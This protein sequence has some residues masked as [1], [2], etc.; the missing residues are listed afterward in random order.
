MVRNI[1][2]LVSLMIASKCYA[3]DTGNTVDAKAIYNAIKQSPTEIKQ[4]GTGYRQLSKLIPGVVNCRLTLLGWDV[5]DCSFG[6]TH[7]GFSLIDQAYDMLDVE[8]ILIK[9]DQEGKWYKK[10]VG[11]LTCVK[12]IFEKPIFA[13]DVFYYSKSGCQIKLHMGNIDFEHLPL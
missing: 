4:E 2:I 11:G 12:L 5:Y 7:Q 3:T 6:S 9:S 10:Y 1:L 8:E 13:I